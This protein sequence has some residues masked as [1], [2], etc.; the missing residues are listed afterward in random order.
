MRNDREVS[1]QNLNGLILAQSALVGMAVGLFDSQ[2]WLPGGAGATHYVNG[3]TYAMGALAIQVVATYFF[4]M[5][6]EENMIERARVAD[7]QRTRNMAFQD[8]Q[9]NY[10]QRRMDME[11]RMQEMQMEKELIWMQQN[12]GEMM[13]TN[14]NIGLTVPSSSNLSQDASMSLGLDQIGQ[15]V[16]SETPVAP[17]A[18]SDG[19]VRLKADGTPDRRYKSE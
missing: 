17:R 16:K 4:K 5:F 8:Q 6:F 10:D 2:L 19:N 14:Q 9:F 3:M 12:P 1:S 11:L 15:T 13:P 18:L 7:M